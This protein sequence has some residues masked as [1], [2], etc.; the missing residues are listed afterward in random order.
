LILANARPAL[1]TVA[2]FE[3]KLTQPRD[4]WLSDRAAL[5]LVLALLLRAG[6]NM[7]TSRHIGLFDAQ[8]VISA[9]LL[10][11]IYLSGSLV[12]RRLE[13]FTLWLTGGLSWLVALTTLFWWA[14]WWQVLALREYRAGWTL[15]VAA[16]L[17]L[18]GLIVRLIQRQ[19]ALAAI[20]R[21]GHRWIIDWATPRPVL[22]RM[23]ARRLLRMLGYRGPA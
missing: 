3:E 18:S 10:G 7:A 2:V 21:H 1:Y 16:A 19:R 23:F 15:Y 13:H 22:V 5:A 11:L 8:L 9:L 6:W 20:G 4:Y 14:G 12:P 17:V